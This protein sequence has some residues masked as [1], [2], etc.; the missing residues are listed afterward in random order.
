MSASS[1]LPLHQI[2]LTD[3]EHQWLE[4]LQLSCATNVDRNQAF[5]LLNSERVSIP[6]RRGAVIRAFNRGEI[7]TAFVSGRA[8]ASARDVVLWALTRKYT[9][10]GN[11]R[12]STHA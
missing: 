12:K 11:D 9:S 5:D 4:S 6:Y 1:T 3:E 10:R 2:D 8:L 7:P